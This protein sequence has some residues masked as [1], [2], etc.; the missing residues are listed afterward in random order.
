MFEKERW[1]TAL[2]GNIFRKRQ[3]PLKGDCSLPWMSTVFSFF[4]GD[5]TIVDSCSACVSPSLCVLVSQSRCRKTGSR[6]MTPQ[7]GRRAA[8]A[9]AVE[10][11]L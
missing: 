2:T 11:L 5:Q 10:M 4:S 7:K 8:A 3:A 9:V 6:V 1:Q